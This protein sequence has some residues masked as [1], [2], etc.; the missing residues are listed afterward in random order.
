MFCSE[1]TINEIVKYL[2]NFNPVK[3][4][5]NG[6]VL[7]NDYDSFNGEYKSM[8]CVIHNRIRGFE[9]SIVKSIKI[10][11]VDFHHSIVTMHGEYVDE[12]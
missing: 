4:T 12:K 11:I 8:P 10:D 2:S 6:M 9:N 7:Y 5:F 3:A 1:V